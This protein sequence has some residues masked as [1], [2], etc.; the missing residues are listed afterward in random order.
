MLAYRYLSRKNAYGVWNRP[1]WG[2]LQTLM[3]SNER[4]KPIYAADN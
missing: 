4:G 3:R 1:S 2:K